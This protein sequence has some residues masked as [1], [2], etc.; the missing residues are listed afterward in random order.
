MP[1]KTI[2][3]YCTHVNQIQLKYHGGVMFRGFL[4]GITDPLFETIKRSG[5]D[6]G[7]D[8]LKRKI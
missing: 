7:S 8:L 5:H 2:E 4:V 3:D 6:E 1:F